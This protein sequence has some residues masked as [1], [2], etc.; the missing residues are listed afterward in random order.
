MKKTYWTISIGD[1]W[2]FTVDIL[3]WSFL[4]NLKFNDKMFWSFNF[5]CFCID[6][7]Y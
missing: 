1:H 6:Y 3:D 5:L 4:F 7:W 2:S